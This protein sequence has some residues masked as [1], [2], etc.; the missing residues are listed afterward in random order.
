MIQTLQKEKR[1]GIDRVLSDEQKEMLLFIYQA[2]K[3]AR[4]IYITL[5]KI[6]TDE[7]TFTSM[8]ISEQRHIDSARSLCDKYAV[9]TS[10][11]DEDTVGEFNSPVLQIL[12]NTCTEKG[13]KSLLDAFEVSEFIEMTDID[14]LEQASVGM[15]SDVVFVYKDLKESSLSHI[16]AFQTAILKV[17]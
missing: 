8:Q 17:A 5:G 9:S 15:P 6:Y 7:Y 3:V 16:D 12:Y 4:D 10:S 11:I 1:P 14:D 2:E 13:R